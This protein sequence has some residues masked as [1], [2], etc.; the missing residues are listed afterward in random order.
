MAKNILIADDS[1]TIQ[2]VVGITLASGDYELSSAH[3]EEELSTEIESE[4][5][6]LVLLDFKLSETKS[7][8]DLAKMIRAKNNQTKVIVM[9]G[10]FDSVEDHEL[11]ECGI[12]DKVIKPF[13]SSKFIEKVERVLNEEASELNLDTNHHDEDS[14]SEWV[15]DSP[16]IEDKSDLEE[17]S[18]GDSI[19]SE[20]N[21]LEEEVEGWGIEIPGV[22]GKSSKEN[23]TELPPV[24]EASGTNRDDHQES[25]EAAEIEALPSDDDLDFP[26]LNM[27]GNTYENIQTTPASL[28]EEVVQEESSDDFWAVDEDTANEF[29]ANENSNATES[30]EASHHGDEH[31]P[32]LD[33]SELSDVEPEESFVLEEQ[34]GEDVRLESFDLALIEESVLSKIKPMIEKLVEEAIEKKLSDK[35]EHVAW[36]VIPDL[37]ENLIKKEIENLSTQ[38]RNS[39]Q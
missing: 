30:D 5:Y 31:S 3:S 10:T 38:A 29:N 23:E 15:L 20:R 4:N 7:G 18:L 25:E 32:S 11:N 22:I 12:S 34:T 8:Y 36:E 17:I 19:D 21:P 26:D 28:T 2:K 39:N 24:I 35:A 6:D 1:L 37:A 13:E 9:L 33:L 16:E 27:S 14:T